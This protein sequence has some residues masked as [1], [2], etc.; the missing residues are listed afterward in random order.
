M[1][2]LVLLLNMY[3]S[4]I[5]IT[6]KKLPCHQ[7]SLGLVKRIVCSIGQEQLKACQEAG[8][9]LYPVKG[10]RRFEVAAQGKDRWR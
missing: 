9:I 8:N 3:N 7:E 10:N 1:F 5:A 2:H 4:I 6:N